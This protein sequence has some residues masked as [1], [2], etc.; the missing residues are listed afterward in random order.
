MKAITLLLILGLS[1]LVGA[2]YLVRQHR[3][4][5]TVPADPSGDAPPALSKR[6]NRFVLPTWCWL[7]AAFAV[8]AAIVL[9]GWL[10]WPAPTDA[11]SLL[12]VTLGATPIAEVEESGF[13]Y[14]E[15]DKEV[16]F[17][18]TD[19]HARLVIPIDR[20]KPPQALFVEIFVYRPP[21][22]AGWMRLVANQQ[23]IFHQDIRNYKFRRT[24]DLRGIDLGDKLVLDL[25]SD[26]FA[27]QGVM[28]NGT[29]NDPRT[30]GVQV[31]AVK[32]LASLAPPQ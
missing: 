14:Q 25:I 28:D 29:N 4:V 9:A 6:K 19:G 2:W 16:P 21:Q 27:P 23:E 18:W 1:F 7:L 30:L 20:T 10:L 8:G 26:T 15:Y 31:R 24:F 11:A 12:N 22:V 5:V 32:L 3:R 13:S 17:R